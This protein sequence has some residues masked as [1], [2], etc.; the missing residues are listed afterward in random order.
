MKSMSSAEL[1]HL[2]YTE[3]QETMYVND[4]HEPKARSN[5][6]AIALSASSKSA[7]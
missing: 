4:L 6:C 2:Y 3:I 7:R 1:L 5:F